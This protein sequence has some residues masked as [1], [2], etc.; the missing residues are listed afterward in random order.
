MDRD[1]VVESIIEALDEQYFEG[2]DLYTKA[3]CLKW[4][5]RAT[6]VRDF[7][8]EFDRLCREENICP[9]CCEGHIRDEVIGSEQLDCFGTMCWHDEYTLICDNCGREF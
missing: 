1:D 8:Y 9:E 6:N 2:D 5:Y 4:L 7:K 3:S